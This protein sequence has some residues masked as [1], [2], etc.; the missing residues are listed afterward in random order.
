[1]A[2]IRALTPL[3]LV[4]VRIPEQFSVFSAIKLPDLKA[5]PRRASTIGALASCPEP[6]SPLSFCAA[7]LL[8]QFSRWV[9][10]HGPASHQRE[11][12]R[13]SPLPPPCRIRWQWHGP[14]GGWLDS[15][16]V[17]VESP[18]MPSRIAGQQCRH[19]FVDR[20]ETSGTARRY[21]DYRTPG[22]RPIRFP[23]RLG[24]N[25]PCFVTKWSCYRT[26]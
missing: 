20:D 1:M 7:R 17:H 15:S 21:T 3:S 9:A 2:I 12:G 19:I 22:G 6:V 11:C 23:R 25:Q 10:R 8:A 16:A 26:T 14:S 5:P 18:E 4:G 24:A 13:S